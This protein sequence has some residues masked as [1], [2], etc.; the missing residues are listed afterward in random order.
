[1]A[2]KLR[3]GLALVMVAVVVVVLALT[4]G[5]GAPI[6]AAPTV[7]TSAPPRGANEVAAWSK[8]DPVS[9]LP[10]SFPAG[11]HLRCEIW[12]DAEWCWPQG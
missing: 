5:S 2:V 7:S 3:L 4:T 11:D 8:A 10:V 12:H 9:V 6:V 1:M